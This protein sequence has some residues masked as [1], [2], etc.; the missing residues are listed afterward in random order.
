MILMV[1]GN[2]IFTRTET[3]IPTGDFFY[4]PSLSMEFI[5]EKL[6]LIENIFKCIH[7]VYQNTGDSGEFQFIREF[8][9]IVKKSYTNMTLEYLEIFNEKNMQDLDLFVN[10]W[11]IQKKHLEEHW[12]CYKVIARTITD[13]KKTQ[14]VSFND[15]F[16]KNSES[17]MN[18]IK[19][20]QIDLDK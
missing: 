17:F 7:N 1:L 20:P 10:K 15:I 3:K 4:F 9:E 11:S 12:E 19:L 8:G 5:K 16:K 2:R 18:D 6:Q 13:I 14:L